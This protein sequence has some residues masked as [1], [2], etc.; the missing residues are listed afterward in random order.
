MNNSSSR[1]ASLAKFMG[2]WKKKY[3]KLEFYLQT[4][5]GV[6]WSSF[7]FFSSERTDYYLSIEDLW[8]SKNIFFCL[9]CSINEDYVNFFY[10]WSLRMTDTYLKDTQWYL[11]KW[12]NNINFDISEVYFI[13]SFFQVRKLKSV[14]LNNFPKA[15]DS[16]S[17]AFHIY[18]NI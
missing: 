18:L 9:Y 15:F 10:I 2:Q 8:P 1:T 3:W 12:I 11:R 16:T 13:Y 17:Y 7:N 6:T 5:C 4:K 14:K